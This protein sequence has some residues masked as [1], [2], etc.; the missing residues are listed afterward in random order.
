MVIDMLY[1]LTFLAL[2]Q[3]KESLFLQSLVIECMSFLTPIVSKAVVIIL[4]V[5]EDMAVV[6]NDLLFLN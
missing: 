6:F 3:Q 4:S 1:L 2:L 5:V